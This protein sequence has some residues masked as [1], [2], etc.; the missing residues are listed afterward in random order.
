MPPT[1]LMHG[2]YVVDQVKT[3]MI[4]ANASLANPDYA[5][6]EIQMRLTNCHTILCYQIDLAFDNKQ[7]TYASLGTSFISIASVST[8][9]RS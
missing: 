4:E 7:T 5:V 8:W 2:I 3:G 9:I 1:V 6:Y